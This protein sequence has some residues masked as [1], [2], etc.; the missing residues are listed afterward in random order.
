MTFTFICNPYLN[1]SRISKHLPH[2]ISYIVTVQAGGRRIDRTFYVEFR[3]FTFCYLHG[4]R[5]S[6]QMASG[7]E[8]ILPMCKLQTGALCLK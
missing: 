4:Q 7:K 3:E 1:S 5:T 2:S 8:S 6:S